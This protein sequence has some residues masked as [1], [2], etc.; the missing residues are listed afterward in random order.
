APAEQQRAPRE[1][2]RLRLVEQQARG[3]ARNA[4]RPQ[5]LPAERAS[6]FEPLIHCPL[7]MRLRSLPGRVERTVARLTR[8]LRTTEWRVVHL[9][10][11]RTPAVGRALFAYV[12]DPFLLPPGR[13]ISHAHTHDWESWRMATTLAE[14]GF[15]V[16]V[17]HWTNTAFVP[18]ARYDVAIDVRL[19]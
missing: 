13:E 9:P 19:L 2:A 4:H 14:L 10:A 8:K 1:R 5:I 12:I 7:R 3:A 17:L 6:L 18:R 11:A 15:E 16:D